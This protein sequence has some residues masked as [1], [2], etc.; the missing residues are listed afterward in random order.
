MASMFSDNILIGLDIGS[1][2]IKMAEMR[3]TK[4][5]KELLTFGSATH[6]LNLDGHWDSQKLRKLSI[7][8]DDIM[9]SNR[10][11][12]VR[13]VFSVMS[14][15]VYVTTMDFDKSWDK[16][17]IQTEIERQSP[18]FLPAPPDEMRLSWKQIK[19]DSISQEFSNKQR[20]SIKAL[21]D[22][23]I[24]NSKNLL[25]H[26]NLDGIII[27][28]QTESQIRS[29]LTGDTGNTVLVDIGDTQSTFNMIVNGSLRS[30]SHIAIGTGQITKDLANS[31]GI[32]MDIAEL[33]KKDLHLI[34]LMQLPKPVLDFFKVLK[35]E[36]TTFVNLNKKIGQPSNKV[37]VTGGGIMTAGFTEFFQ[38]FEI[39]VYFGNSL[40]DISVNDEFLPIITPL[41]N[42]FAA[43]IGLAIWEEG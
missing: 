11:R 25:E 14:K 41:N 23:V 5:K 24:D 12:G 29:L 33:F 34:N 13:T 40:R 38:T 10:F 8:I 36:L 35:L 21:P 30:S 16:K 26:I 20:I 1:S 2:S 43:A 32:D 31:L 15:D 39:P 37:V 9:S 28:N 42:Q 22:F 6:S 4:N 7:I 17:K 19:M 18:Y 3:H 27:E